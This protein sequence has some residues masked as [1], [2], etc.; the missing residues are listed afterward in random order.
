M[1]KIFKTINYRSYKHF[2]NEAYR[3]SLLRELSKEVFVNNNDG[4]QRFCDISINILNRHAPR[5]RKHARGNQ[6]PFVT[7]GPSK[8]I[9]KRSTL[10]NNFFKNRIGKI[11]PYI[12]N[13]RTTAS[14]F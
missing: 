11:N 13:K 3:E 14:H 8:A 4:L 7:K 10:Q 12:R 5:K 1:V 9:M 2:A 6:M